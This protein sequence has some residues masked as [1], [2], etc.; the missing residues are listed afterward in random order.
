MHSRC[1]FF[2]QSRTFGTAATCRRGGADFRRA[3]FFFRKIIF[4]QQMHR[5]QMI[6]LHAFERRFPFAAKRGDGLRVVDIHAFLQ[7]MPRQRAIHRARVHINVA[8]RLRHELRV[9]ALA[10]R[11]RAVNG[12]DNRLFQIQS[13]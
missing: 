5:A 8:E 1:F 9:R 7:A 10:A 12:N 13:F 2:I 6:F 11:A 4:H 3:D